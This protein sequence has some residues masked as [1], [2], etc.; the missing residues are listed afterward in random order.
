MVTWLQAWAACINGKW[1]IMLYFV[2]TFD[3]KKI[4]GHVV[5]H[6]GLVSLFWSAV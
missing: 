4:I 1:C 2:T 6:S 3:Q 5:L